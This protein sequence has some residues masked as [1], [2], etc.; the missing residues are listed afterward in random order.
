LLLKERRNY[1]S[2]ALGGNPAALVGVRDQCDNPMAK[3]RAVQAIEVIAAED[4]GRVS[5]AGGGYPQAITIN[6]LAADGS[7]VAIDAGPPALPALPPNVEPV[8]LDDAD[9]ADPAEP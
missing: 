2:F 3:V 8:V 4:A 5:H 1:L 9:P 7:Q 6:V